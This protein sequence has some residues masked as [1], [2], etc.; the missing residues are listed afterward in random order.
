MPKGLENPESIAVQVRTVQEQQNDHHQ[1]HHYSTKKNEF[2]FDASMEIVF[3][4]RLK[5]L[6][7]NASGKFFQTKSRAKSGAI[8]SAG[9]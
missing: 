7:G 1:Q 5:L 8:T 2:V 9:R 6:Q 3:A 4:S